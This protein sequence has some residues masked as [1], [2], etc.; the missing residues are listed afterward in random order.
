[1]P[2]LL[3]AAGFMPLGTNLTLREEPPPPPETRS[4]RGRGAAISRSALGASRSEL[5]IEGKSSM[6]REELVV[7][8]WDPCRQKHARPGGEVLPPP[9]SCSAPLDPSSP[10]LPG[11]HAGV[12]RAL[13]WEREMEALEREGD[14]TTPL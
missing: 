13:V 14:A 4:R 9:D 3:G 7:A 6:L 5:A 2:V 1:M 8:A 12:A 10:P 11:I